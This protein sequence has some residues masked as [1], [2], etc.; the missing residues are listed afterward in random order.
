M[1][2]INVSESTIFLD[3]IGVAVI[4]SRNKKPFYIDDRV[5][6]KSKALKYAIKSRMIVDVTDGI[7]DVLPKP[8]SQEEIA[9]QA[10]QEHRSLFDQQQSM[11]C[12]A[13]PVLEKP[14][15]KRAPPSSPGSAIEDFRK[16]GSMSVVWT[17][18]ACFLPSELVSTPGGSIPIS[19][20]RVGDKVFTHKGRIRKIVNVFSRPYKGIMVQIK[21]VLDSEDILATPNHPFFA[22]R[23]TTFVKRQSQICKPT[24]KTQYDKRHTKYG[25]YNVCAQRPYK[26]YEIS[27]IETAN[28]DNTCFLVMPKLNPTRIIKE[29]N[30]QDFLPEDYT[31]FA[32][33]DT[34]IWPSSVGNRTPK[35]TV[36]RMMGIPTSW[37]YQINKL[38]KDNKESLSAVLCD[39]GQKKPIYDPVMGNKIPS[40]ISLDPRMGEL[41][42]LYVAEGSANKIASFSL[43]EKETHI[44]KT[45]RKS[46]K[47]I[48]GLEC[49]FS[50]NHSKKSLQVTINNPVLAGFLKGCC[51]ESAQS[52]TVPEFIFEAE[53]NTVTAFIRGLWKGDGTK[54]ARKKDNTIKYGT[55]SPSLA[56]GLR[57]LLS[58]FGVMSSISTESPKWKKYKNGKSYLSKKFYVLR[59]SGQQLYEN[60][61]LT[62]FEFNNGTRRVSYS[63]K[64][65]CFWSDHGTAAKIT[66][67]DR[68]NYDGMVHNIEVEEDH[69]YIVRG[70]AVK[71]CDAGG[72]ASMNRNFMFG[73]A[74]GKGVNVRYDHLASMHD[75]DQKRFDKLKSLRSNRV[76]ADAPKIYGMTAPLIYSW[77]R[78]K[79]LFTMMETRRL[80]PDYVE[81]CNCADEI[82]V[83]SRWCKETF[84]ESGVKKPIS[85]VPLGVDTD[86]YYPD[87]D[88]VNFSVDMKDFVF[89]SVF[90][91]SMRKGYDV[92]LKAYLEEFTS[93]DPVTLLISS[94]YF[95]ST[96]ES[97]KKVIR[98]D[99]ARV[100]SMVS[101]PK[102]P[103]VVLFGDVLSVDMMPMLYGLADCY[104]LPSRGEGFGLPFCEAGACRIPVI[105]T[106]YSGQTDFLDDDNSY[107]IDVDGFRC[108]D[109]SLAWISYFYE[110]AEFPVLGP[111]AVEQTRAHMRHVFE[112]QEEAKRKA[113][114]L[115]DRVVKEYSW[116]VCISKMYEKLK[117]TFDELSRK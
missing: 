49:S 35:S 8:V 81:R 53:D 87:A 26:A 82:V 97:K 29:I 10:A 21:N 77:D 5:A 56:Y 114:R 74:D 45:I 33:D 30:I 41:L 102:K 99:V 108:A 100:S 36:A 54:K 27:H 55:S 85:V 101:N 110:N 68:V 92:L 39:V 9:G 47:S 96:D 71:N 78:Y 7:P 48:F 98:D 105:A 70:R 31:H 44:A 95:G 4:Y 84:L 73:L 38:G 18:P 37:V 115:Y 60:Q 104:V 1:K 28:L 83:P 17:G 103:H 43:H 42:G 40:R 94:R 11:L 6:K 32:Y 112:N 64:R 59:I 90:G 76:P 15:P 107:L 91:W 89:L 72:Y 51:G 25:T 34:H 14:K 63:R 66:K 62:D 24:C 86:I 79:M 2:V 52:K 88:P 109:D 22:I 69:S 13:D 57:L 61:W 50:K 19:R 80:H 46:I 23:G 58:R 106:R 111:T 113:G 75:L 67:I 65:N 116:D 12:N 117:L 20:L 16:D 3:D 93:D